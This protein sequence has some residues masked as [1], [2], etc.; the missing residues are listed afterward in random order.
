MTTAIFADTSYLIALIDR[1]DHLHPHAVELAATLGS[2]TIVTTELVLIEWLNAFSR[3]GPLSRDAVLSAYHALA[4]D[5][6]V[7]VVNQSQR[8]FRAALIH[9]SRHSDKAW[10]LTDCTSFVVMQQRGIRDAL[11]HDRHFVQAG[12]RAL[13]RQ[14]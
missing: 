13:L 10:S 14:G 11:T 12:F 1:R 9:F 2:R 4:R 8:L 7:E 6:Q 3:P 5:R